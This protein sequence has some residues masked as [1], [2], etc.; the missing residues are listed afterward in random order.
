MIRFVPLRCHFTLFAPQ[1]S[2]AE[3]VTIFS[4]PSHPLGS[5]IQGVIPISFHRYKPRAE[6][7]Y[8]VGGNILGTYP[9]PAQ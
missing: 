5:S 6:G 9:L 7:L 1:T 3:W 4:T 8:S 2:G